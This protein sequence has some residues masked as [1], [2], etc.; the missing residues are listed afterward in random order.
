MDMEEQEIS[1]KE[2]RETYMR[3]S[4]K[5]ARGKEKKRGMEEE[6]GRQIK[7][8]EGGSSGKQKNKRKREERERGHINMCE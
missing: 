7:T 2:K 8:R 6:R 1:G 4:K 3:A 5:Q